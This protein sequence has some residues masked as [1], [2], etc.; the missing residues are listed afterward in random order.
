MLPRLETQ[1]M[2][3]LDMGGDDCGVPAQGSDKSAV[4]S[5][6]ID[7]LL[8]DLDSITKRVREDSVET[9]YELLVDCYS[10]QYVQGQIKKQEA[11]CDD[12]RG[13]IQRLA[14]ERRHIKSQQVAAYD[15]IDAIAKNMQSMEQELQGVRGQKD[16]VAMELQEVLN[17]ISQAEAELQDVRARNA[18]MRG[19]ASSSAYRQG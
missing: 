11:R 3:Q 14:A 2:V 4:M 17:E 19:D 9:P 7:Q 8:R 6:T 1:G 13:Q 18:R 12:L 16:A 10:S 15:E 5:G